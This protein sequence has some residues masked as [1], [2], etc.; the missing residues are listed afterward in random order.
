MKAPLAE[1]QSVLDRLGD[2]QPT[3]I[4]HQVLDAM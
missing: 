3:E 2:F 4:L 1:A